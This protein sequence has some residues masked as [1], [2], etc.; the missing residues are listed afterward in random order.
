M[1]YNNFIV[2]P[3]GNAIL[4]VDAQNQLVVSNI[5]NSSNDGISIDVAGKTNYQINY[6]PITEIATGGS[7]KASTIG[8]NSLN[9]VSTIDE[10][11]VW[12]DLQSNL[13][14]YG[15]NKGLL[16][17]NFSIIGLLNG[18]TVF[19]VPVD[20]SDPNPPVV[21]IAVAGLAVAVVGLAVAIYNTVKT[22][23]ATTVTT[24]YDIYGNITGYD[25]S[26]YCDP[27]PFEITFNNQ[28]YIVDTFGI[29]KSYQI[30]N[31]LDVPKIYYPSNVFL[32]GSN[33]NQIVITSII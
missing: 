11:Y 26:Y 24:H 13:N 15:F 2:L 25:V 6:D 4:T 29:K 18:Q 33:I 10:Q 32:T 3:L 1:I 12:H 22:K 20:N 30:S 17:K 23:R 14:V 27:I 31:Q 7:L 19:D 28:T 16:S 5:G 21:W 9:M 8:K